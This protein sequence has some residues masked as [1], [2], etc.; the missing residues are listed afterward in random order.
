[1]FV[2]EVIR[3]SKKHNLQKEVELDF[4]DY[5]SKH[6]LSVQ[7]KSLQHD[8]KPKNKMQGKILS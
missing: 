8:A 3:G 4:I 7:Q 5:F 2:S 6:K 1:M